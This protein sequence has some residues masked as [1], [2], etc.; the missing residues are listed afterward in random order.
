MSSLQYSLMN[1][2]IYRK[3]AKRGTSAKDRYEASEKAYLSNMGKRG[4]APIRADMNWMI[5]ESNR[6][7]TIKNL[8]LLKRYKGYE[9]LPNYPHFQSWQNFLHAHPYDK[10]Q[11]GSFKNYLIQ[12]KQLRT[13]F[14]S[15]VNMNETPVQQSQNV[16]PN[17]VQM[18]SQTSPGTVDYLRTQPP[19]YIDIL[20][21]SSNPFTQSMQTALFKNVMRP[22]I[23]SLKSL[24][25][26]VLARQ[27]P[28]PL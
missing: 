1:A 24:A 26:Q 12:M 4:L 2:G 28:V 9:D 18:L 14:P 27:I 22:N 19:S 25:S 17:Y 21:D 23:P 6:R 15:V 8:N 20:S 3:T 13:S 11:F 16:P 5:E 10:S 7:R